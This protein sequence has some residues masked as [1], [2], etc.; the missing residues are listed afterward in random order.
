MAGVDALFMTPYALNTS[1]AASVDVRPSQVTPENTNVSCAALAAAFNET[2]R[3]R[4]ARVERKSFLRSAI[5]TVSW[6][7]V[8]YPPG[9]PEPRTRATRQDGNR[10]ARAT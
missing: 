5:M 1:F 6:L 9:T 3:P 10:G 4:P 7:V 2:R 8:N